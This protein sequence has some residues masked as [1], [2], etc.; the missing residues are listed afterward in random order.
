MPRKDPAT[1]KFPQKS[2]PRLSAEEAKERARERQRQKR[3]RRREE[4]TAK[5]VAVTTSDILRDHLL[6]SVYYRT[7]HELNSMK[8][9]ID[10]TKLSPSS[11]IKQ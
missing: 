6:A 7:R 4:R 10:L 2:H 5:N 9:D 3:I 8:N 11:R 1:L